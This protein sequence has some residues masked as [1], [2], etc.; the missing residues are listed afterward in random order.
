MN[1][2]RCDGPLY[3][4]ADTYGRFLSCL[5]CGYLEPLD[6]YDPSGKT[7]PIRV[8]KGGKSRPRLR[9]MTSGQRHPRQ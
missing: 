6:L 7:E 1:C 4:D 9:G 3:H 2:P 5:I 8:R